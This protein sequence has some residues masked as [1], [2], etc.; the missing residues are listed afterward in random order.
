MIET[1]NIK[2]ARDKNPM[3]FE[4]GAEIL[5]Y[6]PIKIITESE[7]LKKRN[8]N[9]PVISTMLKETKILDSNSILKKFS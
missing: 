5:K 4:K 2:T 9:N 7:R 3:L 8:V 6:F 1:M